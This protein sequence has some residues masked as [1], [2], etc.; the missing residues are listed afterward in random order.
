[1]VEFEAWKK[2]LSILKPI[3]GNYK[4]QSLLMFSH[5]LSYHSKYIPACFMK[6]L[7]GNA[8]WYLV[9]NDLAHWNALV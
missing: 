9:N 7:K 1:M 3:H 8:A 5:K 4:L 2:L 6:T